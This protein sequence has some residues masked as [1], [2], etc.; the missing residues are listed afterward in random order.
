[1]LMYM[2]VKLIYIYYVDLHILLTIVSASAVALCIAHGLR[3]M[4]A[5]SLVHHIF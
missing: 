4:R 5:C 3:L 2:Q 1:M